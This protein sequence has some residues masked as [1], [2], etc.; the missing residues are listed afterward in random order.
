MDAMHT[1]HRLNR[2]FQ[3]EGKAID[4]FLRGFC[5]CAEKKNKIGN[6]NSKLVEKLDSIHF[7]KMGAEVFGGPPALARKKKS[8]SITVGSL[9]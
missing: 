7:S 2:D 9:N 8:A 6:E 5:F 3:R 4:S 1:A